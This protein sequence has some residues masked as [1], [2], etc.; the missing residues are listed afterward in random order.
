MENWGSQEKVS[1]ARKARDSQDPAGTVL[2]EIPN[3]GDENLL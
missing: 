2:A 3:Q 1:D